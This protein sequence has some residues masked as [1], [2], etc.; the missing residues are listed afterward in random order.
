MVGR[1]KVGKGKVGRDARER[2]V[3]GRPEEGVNSPE[4]GDQVSLN[5]LIYM[6]ESYLGFSARV[7]HILNCQATIS[8]ALDLFLKGSETHLVS[9]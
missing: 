9:H 5:H 1:G 4:T 8:L 3:P 6:M 2:E 7:V